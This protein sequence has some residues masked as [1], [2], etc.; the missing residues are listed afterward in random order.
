MSDYDIQLQDNIIVRG[1]GSATSLSDLSDVTL[2]TP[3]SGQVLKYDGEKWINA[4]ESGGGGSD[5]LWYPSVS[6]QGVISWTK[7]SS[8]TTPTAVDIAQIV[9]DALTIAENQGV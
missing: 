3:T 5:E 8:S 4:N 2:T 9:L 6:E 7:S 1:E